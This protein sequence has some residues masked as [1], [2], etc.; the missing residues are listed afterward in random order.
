[1]WISKSES[2]KHV[3]LGKVE[4]GVQ[5]Y[6]FK[7]T[8]QDTE[9]E[10]WRQIAVAGDH[11]LE[12]LGRVAACV[13]GWI[14]RF[15]HFWGPDGEFI[16][17]RDPYTFGVEMEEPKTNE[18]KSRLSRD[19]IISDLFN[20]LDR[21]TAVM[22]YGS[23]GW[24]HDITLVKIRERDQKYYPKCIGGENA[25]PP[26][27]CGGSDGY[28]NLLEALKDPKH[29]EHKDMKEWMDDMGYKK[30]NPTKFKVSS[31]IIGE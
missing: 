28:R 6:E 3:L 7:V 15:F 8:L 18:P 9:P 11:T 1:M 19:I 23:D 16:E 25:C 12:Q 13:I 20:L 2:R 26:E 31:V 24:L 10:V 29:E 22:D 5:I 30:F 21:T 14:P 27:D 17:G 4:K